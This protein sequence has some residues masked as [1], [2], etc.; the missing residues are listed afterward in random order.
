MGRN[1]VT[2]ILLQNPLKA[3]SNLKFQAKKELKIKELR[4]RIKL[5]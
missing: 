2:F 1:L 4:K 3:S 5:S